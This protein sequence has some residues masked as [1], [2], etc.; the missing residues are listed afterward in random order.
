VLGL[1]LLVLLI[2]GERLLLQ[3]GE[4]LVLLVQGEQR[5]LMLVVL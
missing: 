5:V 3:Q 2:Q 1:V 4:R